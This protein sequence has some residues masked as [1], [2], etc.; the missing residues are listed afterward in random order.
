VE[1]ADAYRVTLEGDLPLDQVPLDESNIVVQAAVALAEAIGHDGAAAF[2]IHKNIPVG[3]GMGG[4][5][6]DA[7]AALVALNEL[8]GNQADTHTLHT[9]AAGVGADVPFAL[10]GGSALGRG[11]GS[12]L[13]A[14]NSSEFFW[15]LLPIDHHLST[16]EVYAR[17]DALTGGDVEDLPNEL[18]PQLVE[19]LATGDAETLAVFLENDLGPMAADLYPPLI[20]GLMDSEMGG[21]LRTMVS[22][23]GP[24][25]VALTRDASHQADLVQTLNDKGHRPIP[26]VSTPRGAHLV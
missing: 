7:A 8:W 14:L 6:A 1:N 24:T 2:H 15:V 22:G 26:T 12:S 19:A 20:S 9:I 17:F 21:A 11:N 10:S 23:S 25:L 5:S 16:P 3:G 18:P 13:E 4:G